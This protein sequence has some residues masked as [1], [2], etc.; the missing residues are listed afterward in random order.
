MH[1]GAK[2][3]TNEFSKKNWSPLSSNKLHWRNLIKSVLWT[4][5]LAVVKSVKLR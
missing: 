2:K 5:N 3:F 1:T 4:A